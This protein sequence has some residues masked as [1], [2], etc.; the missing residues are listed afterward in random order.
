[1]M[2]AISRT[3]WELDVRNTFNNCLILDIYGAGT[4]TVIASVSIKKPRYSFLVAASPTKSDFYSAMVKLAFLN[5]YR[6]MP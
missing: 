2:L 6:V 5:K 4:S 1:M 3:L